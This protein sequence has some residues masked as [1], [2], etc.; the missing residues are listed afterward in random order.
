M[1]A[2]SPAGSLLRRPG[3]PRGPAGSNGDHHPKGRLQPDRPGPDTSRPPLDGRPPAILP[4]CTIPG[5]GP[6]CWPRPWR[7]SGGWS[8][9]SASA[10]AGSNTRSR[11]SRRIRCHLPPP[12]DARPAAAAAQGCLSSEACRS[13]GGAADLHARAERRPASCGH[14]RR[15]ERSRCRTGQGH[16]RVPGGRAS[17]AGH[18][19]RTGIA[20]TEGHGDVVHRDPGI[21]AAS[22][23]RSPDERSRITSMYPDKGVMCPIWHGTIPCTRTGRDQMHLF[24]LARANARCFLPARG[25]ESPPGGRPTTGPVHGKERHLF[26]KTCQN[27]AIG[28][29]LELL[30][31]GARAGLVTMIAAVAQNDPGAAPIASEAPTRSPDPLYTYRCQ[32]G[33]ARARNCPKTVRN[34]AF[35]AGCRTGGLA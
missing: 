24:A 25:G 10:P 5:P 28:P 9:P 19:G 35:T 33:R 26:G 7:G 3:S 12:A 17:A 1:T 32:G 22:P 21:P 27:S 4:A 14:D 13:R 15:R 2:G 18:A 6:R 8:R 30:A 29:K 23:V 31:A 34:R 11:P 16:P 20:G